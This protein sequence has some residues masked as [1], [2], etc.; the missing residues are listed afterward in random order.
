V[1]LDDAW[2]LVEMAVTRHPDVLESGFGPLGETE[3]VHGDNIG[4][5]SEGLL[6]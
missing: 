3:P 1:E 4:V 5:N 6:A 2:D